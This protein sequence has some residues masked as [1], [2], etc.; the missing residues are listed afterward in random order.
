MSEKALNWS[1]YSFPVALTALICAMAFFWVAVSKP[2]IAMQLITCQVFKES[3]APPST[4]LPSGTSCEARFARALVGASAELT[5]E[6]RATLDVF[7]GVQCCFP[8]GY[9]V[10]SSSL[11]FTLQHP[12]LGSFSFFVHLL[13]AVLGHF[14]GLQQPLA[15]FCALVHVLGAF[16]G[17]FLGFPLGGSFFFFE[18]P[19]VGLFLVFFVV[20][21]FLLV[22]LFGTSL[23]EPLPRPPLALRLANS[24][25]RLDAEGFT[26]IAPRF[27]SC[28]SFAAKWLD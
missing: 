25:A 21:F 7:G 27:V 17:H 14:V 1:S 6:R 9:L 20:F 10:N 19:L 18:P 24:I 13:G 23:V 3:V 5:S 16:A 28:K 4:V 12:V 11:E 15:F 22:V 26:S 2:E 8:L